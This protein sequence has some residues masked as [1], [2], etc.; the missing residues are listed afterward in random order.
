MTHVQAQSKDVPG[1][2]RFSVGAGLLLC[3]PFSPVLWGVNWPVMKRAVTEVPVWTFRSICL[4]RQPGP[5]SFSDLPNCRSELPRA[6]PVRFRSL[7]LIIDLAHV[8]RLGASCPPP[9]SI[10]RGG[11]APRSSPFRHAAV[12]VPAG[13][14]AAGRT[15]GRCHT[16]GSLVAGLAGMA[17][18]DT[19][20]VSVGPGGSRRA[21]WS[22]W[23]RR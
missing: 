4:F 1:A 17:V 23:S 16:V 6:A 7:A 9:P 2:G 5:G 14:A 20:A 13:G 19:A 18:S 21:P 3:W 15:A 11:A 8:T 22:C 10:C 12:G